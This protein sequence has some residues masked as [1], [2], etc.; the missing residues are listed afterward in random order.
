[1]GL[2][3]LGLAKDSEITLVV[4][5]DDESQAIEKLSIL[6]QNKFQL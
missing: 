1:M 4:T 2:M 6:V 3:S 5:G